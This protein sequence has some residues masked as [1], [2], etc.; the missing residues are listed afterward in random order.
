MKNIFPK[1]N[2]DNQLSEEEVLME[3]LKT[4]PDLMK[5]YQQELTKMQ[6][7]NKSATM[8]QPMTNK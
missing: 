2:S 5:K 4:N 7:Q 1:T 3:M 8:Q 6:S